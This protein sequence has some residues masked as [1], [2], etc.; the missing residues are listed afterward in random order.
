MLGVEQTWQKETDYLNTL[1]SILRIETL[2]P[3]WF[4]GEFYQTFKEET[5]PILCSLL[6]KTEADGMLP[7]SFYDAGIILI[8]KPDKDIT[9]KENDRLVSPTNTEAKSS[10]Y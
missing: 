3:C 10:K 7:H 9:G 8:W 2:S 5:I 4:T 1:I 6:E